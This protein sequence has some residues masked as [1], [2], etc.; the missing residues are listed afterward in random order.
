MVSNYTCRNAVL[1]ITY[2][3]PLETAQVLS[4][5]AT[6]RPPRIYFASD[7][8]KDTRDSE[9][10]NQVRMLRRSINWDCEVNEL[11][12]ERNKGCRQGPRAAIDWFFASECQGIILE[13][14]T[15]PNESFFRFCDELL[16]R[17]SD[18]ERVGSIQGSNHVFKKFENSYC[19]SINRGSWGWATW[20]RAWLHYDDE[21]KWL[22]SSQKK[23]IL[24]SVS[25]SG[26]SADHWLEVIPNLADGRFDAWD[27]PWFFSLVSQNMLSIFPR[28]N[29]VSYI[30]YGET[31]THTKGISAI[32]VVSTKS[33]RFPLS[34]PDFVLASFE[35]D[36]ALEKN[37]AWSTSYRIL[38]FLRLALP[39]SILTL[40]KVLR[41][42]IAFISKR[43]L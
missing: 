18:D 33:L 15:V 8:P 37:Y 26:E 13:D 4:S 38:R 2:N 12:S 9:M 6:V 19:F 16:D 32:D 34:H 17:Y 40:L 5:L 1:L 31:A 23:D 25:S 35:F 43:E 22:S 10:V 28:E 29:L 36:L 21:M 11:F 27:W 7:G 24:R 42:R 3:R 20:K 30:G 41:N 14:D 39:N